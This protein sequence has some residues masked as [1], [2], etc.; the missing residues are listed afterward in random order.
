M[1][2]RKRSS[3]HPGE[4]L[5]A[6]APRCLKSSGYFGAID[7]TLFHR[8]WNKKEVNCGRVQYLSVDQY[9]FFLKKVQVVV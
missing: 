1:A 4:V 3:G 6:A 8:I 2:G 7:E 9:L 5:S